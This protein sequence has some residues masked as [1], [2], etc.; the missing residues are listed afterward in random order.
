MNIHNK[1]ISDKVLELLEFHPQA[2]DNDTLLTLLYY[3]EN[4]PTHHK[5]LKSALEIV[6]RNWKIL[7]NIADIESI[8]RARRKLQNE[9]KLYPPS[10]EASA[11]RK[12]I[13]EDHKQ[14]WFDSSDSKP[15]VKTYRAS[16][17]NESW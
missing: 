14:G 6:A 5:E 11:K 7:S 9:K 17:M 1:L 2:R 15:I 10:E 4:C 8:P 13:S 16:G 3:S 12:H